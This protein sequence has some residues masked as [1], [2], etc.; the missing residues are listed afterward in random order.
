MPI[1]K[2]FEENA[3]KSDKF[4]KALKFYN[5]RTDGKLRKQIIVDEGVKT[6]N[7]RNK[8]TSIL[9]FGNFIIFYSREENWHKLNCYDVINDKLDEI[10]GYQIDEPVGDEVK[11][12]IMFSQ[13]FGTRPKPATLKGSKMK[14]KD[15]D[16]FLKDKFVVC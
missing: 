8:D 1:V 6:P 2:T 14:R 16:E 7:F 4:V 3:Y 5:Y 9:K 15:L 11:F 12:H 10:K 13:E